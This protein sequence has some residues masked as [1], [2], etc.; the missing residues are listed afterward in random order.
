MKQ[1]KNGSERKH[2]SGMNISREWEYIHD[3]NNEVTG[4]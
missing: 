4:H 1:K 2:Y 3:Q